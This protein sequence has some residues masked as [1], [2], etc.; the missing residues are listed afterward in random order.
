MEDA[1]VGA[2]IHTLI[3]LDPDVNSSEALNYA[4]TE[5]ITALDKHGNEV[6]GS[7]IFKEFFSVDKNS[8]RVTVLNS[9]Q[10][11]VAAVIRI[12]VL[13]TDIT[14]ANVQQGTGNYYF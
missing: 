3:A 9:L 2:V 7:E 10:R 5:P 12:T 13:V 8:G 11:E 4:A 6:L 1:A 14:A